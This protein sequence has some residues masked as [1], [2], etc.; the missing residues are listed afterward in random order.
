MKGVIDDIIYQNYK[1]T[2]E[3][4]RSDLAQMWDLVRHVPLIAR[5][6]DPFDVKPERASTVG[7]VYISS[8]FMTITERKNG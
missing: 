3:K 1:I 4:G 7:F 8:Y 5:S 6:R 2:Y